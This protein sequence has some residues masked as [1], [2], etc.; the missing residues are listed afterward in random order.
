MSELT[1]VH[2]PS[3]LTAGVARIVITPPVGIYLT[4]F[5]GRP[6]STGIHDDLTA[7][8]LVLCERGPNGDDL[9]SRV[10]LLALD[11]LQ[12]PG[13]GLVPA[14]KARIAEVSGIAPDCI[15]L[16]CSHTHYGPVMA[17][18]R[19]GGGEPEATAYHAMLPHH[20]A[21]VVAMADAARRPVTLAAGRGHVKVGINRRERTPDGKIILGQHPEGDLDS[22]VLVWRFDAADGPAVDPGAPVGW[23]HRAPEPVAVVVNYACHAV[24]LGSR[25]RLVSADFPGSMREVVERLVGGTAL[26]VQGAAGN[27]NPAIGLRPKEDEDPWEAPRRSGYALGGEVARIALVAQ[28][29]EALPLRVA[30]ETVDLPPLMPESL[31]TARARLTELEAQRA[32]QE[33]EGGNPGSR[34]WH[35]TVTRRLKRA[36]EAMEGGEP[37][38]VVRGDVA[39]L[40]IGD[41]AF[42][43]NPSELFCE[44]GMAIKGQ[45]PFPWTGVAGYTDGSVGYI[46]TRAAYPEGGYEVDRACRVN[47]E[48]GEIVEE[49]SVRLLRALA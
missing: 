6:P 9:T 8:A 33:R 47:P 38:P 41:A 15:F 43:T 37:V 34:I 27:I 21:G 20:L 23:V 14:V 31:E 4:G 10:A 13:E 5:A 44:I 11:L 45:S 12:L 26:F 18:E 24:S 1:T 17:G 16:N 19:E 40:R 39:A 42:A 25:M 36:I 2:S 3:H 7:T 35:D 22:E 28:P 46:P 30:R 29:A 32:R 49:T 48:A